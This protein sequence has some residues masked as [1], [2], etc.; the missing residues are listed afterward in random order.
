MHARHAWRVPFS[1]QRR[2]STNPTIS[3]PP[4]GP[5][6]YLG[7]QYV[8]NRDTLP[9]VTF[10]VE[11]RHF[12]AHRIALLASSEAFRAMFNSGYREKDAQVGGLVPSC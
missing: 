11:G 8:N 2:L 1:L 4:A 3:P 6:V 7:A 9:D 10:L 5:Q 12:Y